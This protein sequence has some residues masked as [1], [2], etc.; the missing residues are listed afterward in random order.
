VSKSLTLKV[1]VIVVAEE[2]EEEVK[3]EP[4]LSLTSPSSSDV[5][6]IEKELP[7]KWTQRQ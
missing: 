5:L 6:V 3:D 4:H 7:C 2:R 1:R